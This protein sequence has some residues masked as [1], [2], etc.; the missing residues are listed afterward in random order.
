MAA[1]YLIRHGQ[2]SF[3]KANYDQLSEK[4]IQQSVILG[5]S[6]SKNLSPTLCFAGAMARHEQTQNG[7]YEGFEEPK[8]KPIIFPDL[9]EFDHEDILI[10][11]DKNWLDLEYMNKK[12]ANKPDPKA[13]F[14]QDFV[15]AIKRW[16][17]D[18]YHS[19]YGESWQQ[20]KYRCLKG[21]NDVIK[22]TQTLSANRS[23]KHQH[24]AVFSSGGT[25]SVI[26][27]NILGL[28][29]LESLK[30]NQQIRNTSVS[31]I[32]FSKENISVDYYNNYSHLTS[33]GPTWSTYR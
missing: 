30:L 17:S 9:N 26:L 29:D 8:L 33:S 6:W 32:L 12:Y 20:F 27:A 10:K 5:K 7:F 13:S 22:H 11:F 18:E 2:A 25:I 21:F 14:N 1:I 19:E 15:L 4:G 23:T 3:G 28:S 31:K 16:M 24:I